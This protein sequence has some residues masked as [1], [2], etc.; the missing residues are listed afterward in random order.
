MTNQISS[1][2]QEARHYA[3][4]A[5][6]LPETAWQGL[7]DHLDSVADMAAALGGPLSISAAARVAGILHDLGKYAPAFQA[8]LRGDTTSVDHSTAGAAEILRV[9]SGFDNLIGQLVA[10]AIAGHHTGLP[11]RIGETGTLN[12]RLSQFDANTLDPAWRREIAPQAQGL[13]PEGFLEPKPKSVE[14][15]AFRLSVL[16]RM[17]FSCLVDADY[18][19]TEAFYESVSGAK[20]DRAW[21]SLTDNLPELQ[22]RFDAHMNAMPRSDS[23]VNRLRGEI[24]AHVRARAGDAS[25]FF[26]LTVPTGGGKTLASLAFALDHARRHGHSR[27]IAAIPFTSIIDQ[28]AAIYKHILGEVN[29]LEHHSAIDDERHVARDWRDKLKLAME[30]WAAPIV[31]TT[32]VQLFESLFAS[33]SSRCRKLHNIA[34]S[35]IILDEAQ[36]IPR[37]LLAPCVRILAELVRFYGCTIVLCTAT[38]PAL[39]ERNFLKPSPISLPLEGRELAPD[40]PRLARELKRVTL[41]LAG[42]MTNAD[43]VAALASEPQGLVIVNSRSHALELYA[44][45]K[46]AGLAGPVHLSTRQHAWDRREILAE[47]RQRLKD[48]APCRVIA[49]S[50]IEAGVDLDFSRVWRAEAG[51]D[52]IAQ[53]AG[54]CNREGKREPNAS[55]VTIFKAP[56]HPPPS[57]I[58]GLIGDMTRMAAKHEDL[59]SPAAMADYFGEVYWRLNDRLDGKDILGKFR[60]SG[61]ETDFAYRTAAAEFRMIES[62]MAP[63]I[64]APDGDVESLVHKLSVAEVPSGRLARDLQTYVV[65]APPKARQ[66]LIDNGHV[67]FAAPKLRGDQFAVLHA[68]KLYSRDIGLLWEDADYLGLENSII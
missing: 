46:A 1:T 18:R 57:E 43:L 39:D 48:G 63:V 14:E 31:V 40:P 17:I 24:L 56:D 33:R 38:Q 23:G 12:A 44:D 52:Q 11:D 55:L 37:A 3:H 50:L 51:L 32:N 58:A 54:R 68:Q 15:L 66:K 30:D 4:S 29:V 62:G 20:A 8:R 64:V 42:A 45:A 49:T 6:E 26:T 7:R 35:V 2:P 21:P 61:M 27:I 67:V 25:G 5:Q 28:T 19:D 41:R 16:G 10:Y 22:A 53:A 47:V 60:L 9:T 59:L 65:Q 34:R 36:T 13:M